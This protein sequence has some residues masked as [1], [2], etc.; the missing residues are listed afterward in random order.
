MSI[1]TFDASQVISTLSYLPRGPLLRVIVRG[2]NKTAGNV[3][4]SASGAIRQRRALSA[5]VVRDALAIKKATKDN[6]VSSLVVTGKPI[7]LKD[8]QASQTKRGVTAKVSPGKRKLVSHRGNRAFIVDKIGGHV[9]AREGKPRLPIKKLFGPSL[10]A[11]FL[12]QQVKQAWTAAANDALPKRMAEE[13]KY[14]LSK[15]NK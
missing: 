4:T 15:L 6:L 7:P 3:R 1:I 10:P 12:Q 8:Y 13:A 5:K 2:L 14:E 11:T 9:F